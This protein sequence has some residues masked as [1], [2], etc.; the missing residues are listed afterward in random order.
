ML[1]ALF[2]PGAGVEEPQQQRA[3]R[4]GLRRRPAAHLE[5]PA[6]TLA[7]TLRD[8]PARGRPRRVDFPRQRIEI[9]A[10]DAVAG[11]GQIVEARPRVRRFPARAAIAGPPRCARRRGRSAGGRARARAGSHWPARRRA[12]SRPGRGGGQRGPT[13]RWRRRATA[14]RAPRSPKTRLAILHSPSRTHRAKAAPKGSRGQKKGRETFAPR[15][16]HNRVAG[17]PRSGGPRRT[18]STARERPGSR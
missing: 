16:K 6:R 11:C 1:R 10:L 18:G 14:A 12:L 2:L 9:V 5:H 3:G 8:D 17:P 7:R 13:R 15:P 4:L